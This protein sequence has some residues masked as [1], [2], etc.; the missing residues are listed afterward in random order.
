M[1]FKNGIPWDML[2]M[3]AALLGLGG[4]F[5][6]TGVNTFITNVFAPMI[7]NISGNPFLFVALIC[8]M[9][10]VIRFIII[11]PLMLLTVFIPLLV[12]FAQAAGISPWVVL[13][14]LLAASS[15]WQQ[16]YMSN[17]ALVGFAAYGGESV[18]DYNQLAKL[19]WVYLA[20]NFVALLL[21]V[22]YWMM[23]GLI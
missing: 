21:M 7:E 19:S 4:V 6:E 14:V 12:P 1:D 18:L 20:V 8:L 15:S 23:I 17:F 10:Y 9:I 5:S 22:P 16:L 3:I 2:L 11:N 13:F